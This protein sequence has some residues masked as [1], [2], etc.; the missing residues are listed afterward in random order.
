MIK[1][2]LPLLLVSCFTLAQQT[3]VVN[4]SFPRIATV[5]VTVTDMSAKPRKGEEVIFRGEKTGKIIR[6]YSDAAGKI[7]Q[8]LPPGDNYHVSLKSISDTTQY[9]IIKVP[10]L[11]EDEYF[12]DPFW[13]NIKFAPPKNYRLDNVHFDFDKASLRVDSYAQLTELLE[14]LKRHEEI[15][16]EI[17]GHTDN[18]GTDAHNLKLSQERANTIRNYLISKGIKANRLTAK[19]YGA[20]QPVA[21][22]NSEEGRQ[23]NRRTE[24]RIL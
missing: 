10:A 1:I 23:L 12:T 18:M 15:N 24:L 13:V 21:D 8:L 4:D 5:N 16:A 17:A 20:S 22:N 7:K 2:T 14:Y 11:A 3:T 19:G 6:G 9:T